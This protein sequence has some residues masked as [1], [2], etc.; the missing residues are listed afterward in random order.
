MSKSRD[1]S[2]GNYIKKTPTKNS[3]I[4]FNLLFRRVVEP[5][6]IFIITNE[7]V[8]WNRI[9]SIHLVFKQGSVHFFHYLFPQKNKLF[10]LVKF[11]QFFLFYSIFQLLS[12]L[13]NKSNSKCSVSKRDT[14]I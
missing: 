10:D 4:A 2:D 1:I 11:F 5:V 7:E 8:V 9:I 6:S 12:M 14:K 3:C 13:I